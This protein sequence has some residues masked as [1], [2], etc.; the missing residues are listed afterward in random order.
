MNWDKVHREDR[1]IRWE[2]THGTPMRV[3]PV[4][5]HDEWEH[6]FERLEAIRA[7]VERRHQATRA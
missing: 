1:L 3:H 2:R 7:R 4:L 6:E 5:T